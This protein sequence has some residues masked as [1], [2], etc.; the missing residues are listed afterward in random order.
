LRAL[1]N[2]T[3]YKK[4]LRNRREIQRMIAQTPAVD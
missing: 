4:F 3:E 1:N 2:F